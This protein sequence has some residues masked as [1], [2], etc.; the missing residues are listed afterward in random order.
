M[1]AGY[2]A[3]LRRLF[4]DRAWV[5]SIIDFGHAKQIFPEADVF[6]SIV[7]MQKRGAGVA[8][9]GDDVQV[10]V[11]PRE[12]L[13]IGDL[14]TQ[15]LEAGFELHRSR[16]GEE[17][18]HLEPPGVQRLLD[19]IRKRGVA[20]T[21]FA[22]VKPYYGIKTGCNEA[23]L[24]DT[25]TR[26]RLVAADPRSAEII[27]PYLRGRDVTRWA[28]SWSGLWMIFSRRGIEIDRYPAVKEHLSLHRRSLDPR[29]EEWDEARDGLWP[30]RPEFC[31]DNDGRFINNTIYFLPT[32]DRWLLAVLNS[33]LT[34]W[35][36][37]RNAGRRR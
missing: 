4:G 6:P 25:A 37:G 28:T 12:R 33:P 11:I 34:W 3:P 1:K 15:V 16:F 20:L 23:F 9:P 32:A 2:G 31:S 5:D 19:K 22:G 10:S 24:I 14:R 36:A 17:A 7:V 29:P 21:Q 13:R 30:G 8:A 35:L 18:W 26:D 27:K